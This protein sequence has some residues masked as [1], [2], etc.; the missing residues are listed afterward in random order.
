[1]LCADW[2]LYCLQIKIDYC[3]LTL[4][5]RSEQDVWKTKQLSL[6][7]ANLGNRSHPTEAEAWSVI[8]KEMY[9]YT[10]T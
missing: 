6:V 4:A 3:R 9:I 7:F 10:Y 8:V 1:M 5:A 2:N